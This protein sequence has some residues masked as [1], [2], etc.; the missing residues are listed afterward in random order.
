MNRRALTPQRIT[1]KMRDLGK[2]P[3]HFLHVSKAGG[4]ALKAAIRNE[5]PRHFRLVIHGHRYTLREV[6]V[7]EHVFFVVRDPI[8][9]FVSGFNSRYRRG[10]GAHFREW[11]WEEERVFSRFRSPDSLACALASGEEAARDAMETISHLRWKQV[12]W[13][14]DLELLRARRDDV[15]FVGRQW[16]LDEDFVHLSHVIGL[17]GR[18]LPV[19]AVSAHRGTPELSTQLS[20]HGLKAV[21]EWYADDF[22]LLAELA[23]LGLIGELPEGL[24]I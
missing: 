15:L 6:P 24:R 19:D 9:R 22:E 3:L 13:V 23:R 18:T 7:G 17:T 5:S 11:S 16:L 2:S 1:R 8:A 14:G 10:G 12:R 4:T 20:R 21:R